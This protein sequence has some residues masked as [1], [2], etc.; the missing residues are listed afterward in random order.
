MIVKSFPIAGA[1][2][3]LFSES[4]YSANGTWT[5]NAHGNWSDSFNWLDGIVA[6]G[7]DFT[8]TLGDYITVNRTNTLDGARTIG[9]I[10]A[11]DTSNDYIIT[12]ASTLTLETSSGTPTISIP[13]GRTL[14]VYCPIA[15]TNG[16]YKNATGTLILTGN[17]SYSGGT[18]VTG[19]IITVGHNNAF[20]TGTITISESVTIDTTYGSY[21]QIPNALQV[22]TG[23]TLTTVG[24]TQYFGMTFTGAVSGDGTIQTGSSG[25]DANTREKLGLYSAANTF[26]GTLVNKGGSALINVN[27]LGDGGKIQLYANSTT[28]GFDL[29]AG[30]ASPLLFNNRQIELYG[31]STVNNNN[32]TVSNTITINT[33]LGFNGAGVRTLT[34]GGSN[35]GAN[36]FGGNI[37][38][39]GGSAVS[40]TK[41]GT[42][43]WILSGT[44][45][46]TGATTISG[47]TLEIGGAGILGSNNT[48]SASIANSGTLRYNSTAAQTLN[49]VISGSGTLI[50]DNNTGTL[51]LAGNNT[52]SG[53]TTIRNGTL[54]GVTGGSCSNTAVTVTNAPG[55]AA[56]GVLIN[57]TAKPWV[58][59]NLIIRAATQLKFSFAVEPST[60]TAPLMIRNNLT[61]LTNAVVVVDPANIPAGSTYPLLVVGGTVDT[62]TVPTLSGA[63]GR[64][65]WGG[66]KT[67]YL[68]VSQAGTIILVE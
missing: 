68:T 47:G 19:G 36:T 2:L 6:D 48:Y 32:A 54:W 4:A 35:S 1:C 62:N 28:G 50:K 43:K 60:V 10:T 49:G 22:N 8:A 34:L 17:N 21:P 46:Y 15:G 51:T 20:G 3:V 56:L 23:K 5:N 12:G 9:N 57:D 67:L 40:L 27:S 58:C 33:A 55:T 59:S 11:A 39:N 65:A 31:S 29:N 30:T 26:T 45:T 53:A 25:N 16:L 64:L 66:D 7:A 42:G 61:G 44:N 24:S 18:I 38:N 63:L 13:S 52:Y 14:S 41:D 37:A